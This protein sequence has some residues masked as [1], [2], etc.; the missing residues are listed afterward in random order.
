MSPSGL[1]VG[2]VRISHFSLKA[3]VKVIP[4]SGLVQCCLSAKMVNK[5]TPFIILYH[6]M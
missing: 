1:L 5:F 2:P 6:F 4:G 3:E